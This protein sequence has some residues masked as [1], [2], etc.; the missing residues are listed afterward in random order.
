MIKLQ[1]LIKEARISSA[2][3]DLFKAVR[4]IITKIMKKKES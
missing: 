3:V 4:K 1:D 2:D